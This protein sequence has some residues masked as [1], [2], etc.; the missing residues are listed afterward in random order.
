[1]EPLSDHHPVVLRPHHRDGLC[2]VAPAPELKDRL[3]EQFTRLRGRAPI[4]LAG[5]LTFQPPTHVG[6]NDGLIYPGTYYP[7]GTTAAV[8]RRAALERA[9]LRGQIRVAVVLV[10]FPDRSLPADAAARTERL[11][12]ST[13]ELPHGSVAEYYADVSGGLIGITGKVVG[14]YTLPRGLSAY[15]G[16]DNGTQ[17]ALPNAR[18]LADEALTASAADLDYAPYDNDGDGFVDAYIVVHAGRGAEQTGRT[19]DIWS[20][21]WILPTERTVNGV[22]VYAYLTIPEDANIGVAAHEIGHLVFGWPDLYDPDQSSEGIGD[23]CLMSGGSWGLGGERPTHPSAWCKA[24][25]GWIDVVAPSANGPVTVEDVKTGR[26]AYRLWTNGQDGTEYFLVENR[27]AT[28]YDASLPGAGLLVWHVDDAVEGNTNEAHFKVALE[29]A[30][31]KRQLE[32]NG[33][34]GDA[35][36][37][38][39]G[40]SQVT[41]FTATSTPNSRSYA[42]S[43]TCV[44]ITGIPAPSAAMTVEVSVACDPAAPPPPGD[45]IRTTLETRLRERHG[46]KGP[47]RS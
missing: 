43:D 6:F 17:A 28:G 47:V 11:F 44:A 46:G 8:A 15:A 24:N 36:D 29:Q 33:N 16:A 30:D 37:P 40:T 34:R 12:F 21:K 23:W 20:H 5:H 7:T 25:Q 18:T 19:S 41:T 27:Q 39:P 31:G 9:P 4:L 32:L 38:F 45:T 13:G 42:G 22:K 10:Q 3:R 2:V 1:M 35:G 26:A 14:P